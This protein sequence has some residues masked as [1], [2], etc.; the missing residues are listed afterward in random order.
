M[1][2]GWSSEARQDLL[3]IFNYI[4]QSDPIAASR[5][6]DR[7]EAATIHLAEFPEIGRL[8]RI[9]HGSVEYGW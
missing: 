7:L 6:V 3:D 1:R 8:A 2:I 5:I 4:A 9:I